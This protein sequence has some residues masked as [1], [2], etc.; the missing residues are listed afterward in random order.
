[1]PGQVILYPGPVKYEYTL[2][3][4]SSVLKL[5]FKCLYL[6]MRFYTIK[7]MFN[8][9][10]TYFFEITYTRKIMLI[11]WIL[12]DKIHFRLQ[13]FKARLFFC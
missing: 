1:M 7:S 10:M 2:R 11:L 6:N 9:S 13:I 12:T 4:G 8:D 5:S 3:M